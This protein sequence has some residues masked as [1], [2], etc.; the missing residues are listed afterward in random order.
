LLRCLCFVVAGFSL[1]ESPAQ[2]EA[3]DYG[4]SSPSR[5]NGLVSRSGHEAAR[6]S[7]KFEKFEIPSL[8]KNVLSLA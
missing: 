7:G 6:R 3:C 4:K 5:R 8:R 1:R 2:A